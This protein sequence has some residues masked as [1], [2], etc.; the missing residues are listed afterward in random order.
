MSKLL[1]N[2]MLTAGLLSCLAPARRGRYHRLHVGNHYRP[3]A[4]VNGM[5][6]GPRD[7][8]EFLNQTKGGIAGNK[9]N[10]LLLDGRY[11]LD[12]ELKNLSALCRPGTGGRRSAAGRPAR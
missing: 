3:D 4:L 5:S 10:L 8:L 7:Y 11:K 2:A 1:R 12:E 6:Y 9:V